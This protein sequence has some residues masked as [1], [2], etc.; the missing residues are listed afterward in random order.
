MIFVPSVLRKLILVKRRILLYFKKNNHKFLEMC[1]GDSEILKE[2][3]HDTTRI[4]SCFLD[5]RVVHITESPLHF[6]PF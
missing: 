2:I 4:S 1:N 6:I 3:V 5:F